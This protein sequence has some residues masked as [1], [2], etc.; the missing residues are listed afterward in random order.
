MNK[1]EGCYWWVY[2]CAS[3]YFLVLKDSSDLIHGTYM[4][5]IA[6]SI[7]ELSEVDSLGYATPS[8]EWKYIKNVTSETLREALV[9]VSEHMAKYQEENKRQS[10]IGLH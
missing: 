10:G 3:V 9:N 8:D 6:N 7:E 4:C 5:A 2:K 1:Y